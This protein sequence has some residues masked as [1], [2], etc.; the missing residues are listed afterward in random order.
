MSWSADEEFGGRAFK[1]GRGGEVRF[2]ALGDAWRLLLE[3]FGTWLATMVILFIVYGLVYRLSVLVMGPAFKL[4]FDH[5]LRV[6]QPRHDR[7]ADLVRWLVAAIINGYFLGGL[8]RMAC[9]Q[10]RGE[11]FGVG[12]MFT[13][14]ERLP[15]L[16]G[17]SVLYALACFLGFALCFFPGLV[18][19]GLLMFTWPL[20]VDARLGA[21]DALGTS[22]R[23]LGSQ[24]VAATFFHFVLGLILAFGVALCVVGAVVTGPLYVLAI[25]CLYHDF[26]AG[27]GKKRVG[28]KPVAPPEW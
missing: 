10:V 3:R 26:N 5:G 19:S 8:F 25:A 28:D 12:D 7:P 20:V 18:V 11:P 27:S 16:A 21:P 2:S 6:L 22:W 9:K 13:T 24:W 17:A 14:G 23:W 15:A 1:G 4:D